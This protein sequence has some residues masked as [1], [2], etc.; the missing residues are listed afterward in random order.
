MYKIGLGTCWHSF[1]QYNVRDDYKITH[2]SLHNH[3]EQK[4]DY[5]LK[6]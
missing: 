1:Y 2:I 5:Q 6:L 3:V 4:I